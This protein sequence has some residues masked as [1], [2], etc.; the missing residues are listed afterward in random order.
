M[1][2][3]NI[4]ALGKTG[5][6]EENFYLACLLYPQDLTRNIDSFVVNKDK[7]NVEVLRKEYK[8]AAQKIHDTLYKYSHDKLDF[9]VAKPELSFLF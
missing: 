8:K 1:K 9:F 2:R 4:E 6:F 3:F 7:N 5:T